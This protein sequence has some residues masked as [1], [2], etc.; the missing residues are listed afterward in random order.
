MHRS[1]SPVVSTRPRSPRRG[2]RSA[3]SSTSRVSAPAQ[4]PM[5]ALES[6]VLFAAGDLDLTF[7]GGDGAALINFGAGSNDF[8]SSIV[9]LPGGKS[10]VGGAVRNG[11]NEQFGL[12]R[13]NADGS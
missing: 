10:L 9:A 4:R 13:L 12:A 11:A 1:T 5:E 2:T 8:G 3:L 7:G 6:R